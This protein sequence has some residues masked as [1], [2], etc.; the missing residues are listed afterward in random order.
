VSSRSHLNLRKARRVPAVPV[1]R[2]RGNPGV[3]AE[4]EPARAPEAAARPAAQAPLDGTSLVR[5]PRGAGEF[6]FREKHPP[7]H[8]RNAAH[9]GLQIATLLGGAGAAA[10]RRSPA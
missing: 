6:V 3:K 8:F 7:E 9:G 2:N 5:P 4:A 1:F 10:R